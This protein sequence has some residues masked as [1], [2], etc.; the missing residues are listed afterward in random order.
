MNKL[1]QAILE[2]GLPAIHE[3][4]EEL[5]QTLESFPKAIG[6]EVNETVNAN[7]KK[8]TEAAEAVEQHSNELLENCTKTVEKDLNQAQAK[9][10]VSI[11]DGI[12]AILDP[13][14][15]QLNK[16]VD[17]AQNKTS[18]KFAILSAVIGVA[19]GTAIGIAALQYTVGSDLRRTE[20]INNALFMAQKETNL[21]TLTSEQRNNWEKEFSNKFKASMQV[22][23]SK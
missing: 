17:K 20:A 5:R 19:L 11:S 16:L 13:K 3:D 2:A 9:L 23:N 10:L 1:S 14:L 8:I 18:P 22:I 21:K 15:A 12:N 7:V 6:E 4:I